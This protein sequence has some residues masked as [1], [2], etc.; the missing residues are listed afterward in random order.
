MK[1]TY[2]L[3]SCETKRRYNGS[4]TFIVINIIHHAFNTIPTFLAKQHLSQKVC[5]ILLRRDM[6]SQGFSHGDRLTD[7]MVA[8]RI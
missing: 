2:L 1:N 3:A 7:R 4:Y 5:V 8:H 6:A